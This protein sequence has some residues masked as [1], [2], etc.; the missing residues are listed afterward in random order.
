MLVLT[1]LLTGTEKKCVQYSTLK[2]S[3]CHTLMG[4]KIFTSTYAIHH[5]VSIPLYS[6]AAENNC[7]LVGTHFLSHIGQEAELA[8]VIEM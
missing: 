2:H 5:L 1:N 7:T 3:E 6:T 4:S 8:W